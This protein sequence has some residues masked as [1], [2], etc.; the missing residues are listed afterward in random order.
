MKLLAN[1]QVRIEF[2]SGYLRT[3]YLPYASFVLPPEL[4][5]LAKNIYQLVPFLFLSS[6]LCIII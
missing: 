4:L 5:L 1:K 2:I 6:T 3:D